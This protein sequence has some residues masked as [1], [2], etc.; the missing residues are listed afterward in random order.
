MEGA[1]K[2]KH[3]FISSYLYISHGLRA[4]V[5]GNNTGMGMRNCDSLCII[6]ETIQHLVIRSI[7]KNHVGENQ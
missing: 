7:K 1:Q 5:G 3:L 2:S 4:S 6:V